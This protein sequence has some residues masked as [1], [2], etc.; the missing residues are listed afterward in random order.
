MDVFGSVNTQGD[1]V[2]SPVQE[3]FLMTMIRICTGYMWLPSA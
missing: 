2:I 3:S 1:K